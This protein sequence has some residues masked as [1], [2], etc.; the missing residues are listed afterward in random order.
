[1]QAFLTDVCIRGWH[2]LF[3][4]KPAEQVSNIN[5]LSEAG[6]KGQIVVVLCGPF[7]TTQKALALRKTAVRPDKVVSAFRWLQANNFHYK[8]VVI[9]DPDDLPMPFIIEEGV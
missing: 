3:K 2:T 7:T 4:N 8:D 6:L 9:P 5:L 1:M